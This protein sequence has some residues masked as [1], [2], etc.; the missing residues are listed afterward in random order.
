MDLHHKVNPINNDHQ[1]LSIIIVP[2]AGYTVRAT[3]DP[4]SNELYLHM[5]MSR[6]DND[7]DHFNNDSNSLWIFD[8]ESKKW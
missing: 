4:I 2:A 5:G 1:I 3:I 8:M 6:R 7:G